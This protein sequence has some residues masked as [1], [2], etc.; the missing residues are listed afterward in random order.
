MTASGYNQGRTV[1]GFTVLDRI[2]SAGGSELYLKTNRKRFRSPE[3]RVGTLSNAGLPPPAGDV[4]DPDDHLW[5]QALRNRDETAFERLVDRYYASMFRLALG[6]VR[7]PEEAEEV[8][9]ETWLGV[10]SGLE[11]F[12][13]RSSLKTWIF[14]I[15][16]NRAR[17]RAK[18]EA[19]MIPL[20]A[21]RRIELGGSESGET[22]EVVNQ[23]DWLGLTRPSVA[24]SWG[25]GTPTPAPDDHILGLELRNR[26]DGAIGSLPRR[27]RE[28][29]TL[30]DLDGR[31]SGD[32]ATLLH[33]GRRGRRRR[34]KDLVHGSS[35][36]G[37]SGGRVRMTVVPLPGW[38]S[39]KSSPSCLCAR[40]RAIGRPRP[41]PSSVRA[42]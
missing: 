22:M 21:L 2:I 5:V 34:A 3:E 33:R 20:S 36:P 38:L 17:S 25:L 23:L 26:I 14:R 10:L 15:L 40:P 9:Q 24:G 4:A 37:R 32:A 8:I 12:E 41:A 16:V 6:Y 31:C 35:R 29:I 27:Q 18:R 7:S 28:V 42:R 30:R 11:R 39:M 19:R 1:K 13:G